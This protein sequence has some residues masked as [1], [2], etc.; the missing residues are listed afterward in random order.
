MVRC[1]PNPMIMLLERAPCLA[2]FVGSELPQFVQ[3]M[4]VA[5]AVILASKMFRS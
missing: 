2:S 5:A 4:A 3:V 1:C